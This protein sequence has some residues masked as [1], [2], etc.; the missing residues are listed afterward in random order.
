MRERCETV[1]NRLR[2]IDIVSPH[3][4]AHA[5]KALCVRGI[6]DTVLACNGKS[7]DLTGCILGIKSGIE[8]AELDDPLVACDLDIVRLR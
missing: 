3:H 1:S 8:I 2:L 4:D 7:R 6:E 5:V